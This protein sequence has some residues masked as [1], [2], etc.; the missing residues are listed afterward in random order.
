MLNILKKLY[1][2]YYNNYYQDE[3]VKKFIKHNKKIINLNY[4]INNKHKVLFELSNHKSL[5]TAYSYFSQSIIKNY[6]YEMIAYTFKKKNISDYFNRLFKQTIKKEYESFGVFKFISPNNNFYLKKKAKEIYKKKIEKLKNKKDIEKIKINGILI[7]DLLYDA[8]LKNCK[9]PTIDL[10]DENFKLYSIEFIEIFLFWKNYI[11]QNDVR[12]V[13]CN[14]TV[15]ESAITIRI[16]FTKKNCKCFQV[17]PES[18][19]QLTKKNKFAYK[20]FEVFNYKKI[21]KKFSLKDQRKFRKIANQRIKL[22]FKGVVGVDM[23]YSTKSGYGSKYFKKR[24]IKKSSKLKILIA[25]HDFLDNPHAYSKNIFPD[26]YEWM[27]YLCEFSKNNKYDW[28]VKCHPDFRIES[29]LILK[30]LLKDYPNMKLINPSTSHHQIIKEGI[31]FVFT[32]YGTI[33]WEYPYLGVQCLNATYNNPR[34]R[35][36]FNINP[37]HFYEYKNIIKNLN[38]Y[39]GKIKEIQRKEILKFYYLNYIHFKNRTNWLI[40]DIDKAV[41][42]LGGFRKRKYSLTKSLFYKYWL[43]N[44]NLKNHNHTLNSLKKFIKSRKYFLSSKETHE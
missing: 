3:Y 26:F 7:G 14:H 12:F 34:Y 5:I 4:K 24:I 37:K 31:N 21:F 25:T 13:V 32:M 30:S 17:T 39:I 29:L 36:N 15:Y 18:I 43:E 6:Q 11:F 19:F 20:Q 9:K 1:K 8:Y 42:R 2:F 16:A 22:R 23:G 33:G 40:N 44:F 27:K 41:E 35:Y 28:Y 38:S 10:S